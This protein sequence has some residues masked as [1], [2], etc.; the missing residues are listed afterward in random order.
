M[1]PSTRRA[2]NA[3]TSWS[4]R[5]RRPSVLPASTRYSCLRATSSMPR[6]IDE[7]NGFAT[8]T[9]MNPIAPV[10]D[11]VCRRW[12]A[13]SSGRYP[14]A[15]IACSTRRDQDVADA[16]FTVDDARDRLE[17]HAGA[18]G[19]VAHRGARLVAS[20]TSS[21]L[22]LA[23]GWAAAIDGDEL[24]RPG[25]SE[26]YSQH[27]LTTLSSASLRSLTTLSPTDSVPVNL[28]RDSIRSICQSSVPNPV[29]KSR[30]VNPEG[31]PHE[32]RCIEALVTIPC[33]RRCGGI[34]VRRVR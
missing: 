4:S 20:P 33:R 34:G 15:A 6:R 28:F 11:A 18:K 31:V 32:V 17:A 2:T 5:S 16:A 13:R 22:R 21:P 7:K 3:S 10:R 24:L 25:R 26:P 1:S 29:P 8:S 30:S 9:R 12:R 27:R 23:A 14:S 19:D